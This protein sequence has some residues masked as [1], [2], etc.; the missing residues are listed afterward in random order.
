MEF[1]VV[2]AR[3]VWAC[4]ALFV[5]WFFL[6]LPCYVLVVCSGV[7]LLAF[8]CFVSGLLALPLCGAAPTFLCLPQ[9]K[10]GKRKRLKPPA[11]KWVPWL[12]GGSGASGICRLAHSAS[13]TRQSYLRRRCARRYP[14]HKPSLRFAHMPAWR[15]GRLCP[16][17]LSPASFHSRYE[18]LTVQVSGACSLRES[19]PL[20]SLADPSATHA[21]RSGS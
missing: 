9:R 8:P 19:N 17:P 7:G 1:G 12:G 14:I 11:H 15:R 3:Q 10:V 13:V 16:E 6:A 20:V 4:A 5:V 18:H 21:V 2:P